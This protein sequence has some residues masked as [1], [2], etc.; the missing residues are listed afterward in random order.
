MTITSLLETITPR[1]RD[2]D[3]IDHV[4]RHGVDVSD[5]G[6]DDGECDNAAKA[7]TLLTCIY[8]LLTTSH[9]LDDHSLQVRAHRDHALQVR[10]RRDRAL[11]VRTHR[12]HS[13]QVRAHRDLALRV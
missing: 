7:C 13:L 1:L 9:I 6:G 8:R 11:Q 4:L 12:V 10:A 3:V 5:V 2:F